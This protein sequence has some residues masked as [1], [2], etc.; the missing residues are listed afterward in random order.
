MMSKSCHAS[1]RRIGRQKFIPA[2]LIILLRVQC[3]K[4]MANCRTRE[5]VSTYVRTIRVFSSA[6]VL[7]TF[8]S[9]ARPSSGSHILTMGTL[10]AEM[11]TT[12]SMPPTL[13]G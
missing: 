9:H 10:A 4:I 8:M 7:L 13:I 3:F 6:R 12:F 1:Q 2:S 11:Q 5:S